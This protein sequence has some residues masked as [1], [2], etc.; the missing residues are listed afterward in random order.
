MKRRE[1]R[2]GEERKKSIVIPAVNH[3]YLHVCMDIKGRDH[4]LSYIIG[5][6]IFFPEFTFAVMCVLRSSSFLIGKCLPTWLGFLF[7]VIGA[8]RVGLV[9]GEYMLQMQLLF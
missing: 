8:L 9:D 1:R 7:G 4:F 3:S 6:P 5:A 2:R